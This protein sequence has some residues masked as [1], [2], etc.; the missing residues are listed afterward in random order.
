MAETVDIHMSVSSLGLPRGLER[1]IDD[2]NIKNA[3]HL[4][5][6]LNNQSLKNR[7]FQPSELEIIEDMLRKHGFIE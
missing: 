3:G 7:G 4:R 2:Q 6:S 5:A 1:R